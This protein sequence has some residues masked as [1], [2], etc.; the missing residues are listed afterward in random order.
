MLF[1]AVAASIYILT[2][3]VQVFPFSVSSPAF[4]ICVLFN[5][6]HSDRCEVISHCGLHLHVLED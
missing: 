5:D 2:N 6:V 1:S 3:S 4:V